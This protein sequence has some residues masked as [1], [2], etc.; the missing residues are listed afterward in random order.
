M[1]ILDENIGEDQRK[2]LERWR[3]RVRQ[4]GVDLGRKGMKDQ[5]QVIPLLHSLKQP[6]LF[7]GDLRLY[8]AELVHKAYCIVCIS[9]RPKESA[10]FIRRVLRHPSF[11]TKAKRMGTVVCVSDVGLRAWRVGKEQE[12]ILKWDKN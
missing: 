2:R 6:V 3:I 4:I 7:T 5:N 10:Y 12:L 1:N 9:C 11:N 8:K